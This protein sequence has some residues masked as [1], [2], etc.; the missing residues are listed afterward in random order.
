MG[1]CPHGLTAN[2]FLVCYIVL[3]MYQR[4]TLS[5]VFCKVFPQEGG[6]HVSHTSQKVNFPQHLKSLEQ[7]F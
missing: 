1:D 6:E 5:Q 4:T 2:T 3:L 7:C